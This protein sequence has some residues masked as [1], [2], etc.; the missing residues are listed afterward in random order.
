VFASVLSFLFLFGS[1]EEKERR[2]REVR[3]KMI[4]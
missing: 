1:E 3:K 2:E 4:A